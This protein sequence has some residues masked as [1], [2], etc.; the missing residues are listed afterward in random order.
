MVLV[1][2]GRCDVKGAKDNG[3]MVWN[4]EEG[5]RYENLNGN[6][7]MNAIPSSRRKGNKTLLMLKRPASLRVVRMQVYVGQKGG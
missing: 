3:R 1:V 6:A 4:I 7:R 2:S 5:S